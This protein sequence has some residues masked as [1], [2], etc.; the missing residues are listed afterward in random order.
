MSPLCSRGTPLRMLPDPDC[1]KH[2]QTEI[3]VWKS[4]YL[5]SLF[6]EEE[7][8]SCVI[9]A[10]LLSN[11]SG[12]FEFRTKSHLTKIRSQAKPQQD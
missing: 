2:R 3:V 10:L 1:L 9:K 4:K 7:K 5:K 11:P 8:K 12:W 6:V